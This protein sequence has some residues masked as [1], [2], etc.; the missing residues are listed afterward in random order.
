MCVCVSEV[1]ESQLQS[2]TNSSFLLFHWVSVAIFTLQKVAVSELVCVCVCNFILDCVN[3]V[4]CA[5]GI[6]KAKDVEPN[7]EQVV[8]AR[9]KNW[10]KHY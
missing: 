1:V 8:R 5:N 7:T 10:W 6:L 4:S 3:F 9:W 2:Q